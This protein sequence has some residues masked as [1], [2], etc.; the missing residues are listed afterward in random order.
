MSK[1]YDQIMEKKFKV[2]IADESHY[3]K[4]QEAKRTKAL[5]PILRQASRTILLTGTA[6][7]M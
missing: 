1:Y 3:I 4:N 2:V 5:V 7:G 6:T